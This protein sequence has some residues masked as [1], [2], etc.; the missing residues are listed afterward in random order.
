MVWVFLA[1]Y[2]AG[3]TR[4]GPGRPGS[5]R[6]GSTR[7]SSAGPACAAWSPSRRRSSSPRAS[8]DREI[9]LLIAFTVVAGTLF[10]QGLT[11]PWLA[12]RLDVPP[13]DP[14]DDALARATLLQQASK[15]GFTEL[16][17]AGVRR[18]AR[19]HRPDPAADRPAQLRGLGAPRHDRRPGVAERP[20]RPGPARDD[21]GRAAPGAGD[22]QVGHG[23]LRGDRRRARDA[24]RRGVDDRRRDRGARA[25]QAGQ[26]DPLPDRRGVRRPAARSRWPTYLAAS[27]ARPASTTAPSGSR[28]ATAWSAATSPAATPHRCSTP[29]RTSTRSQHPVMQSVEPDEDWRWCYVHHLTA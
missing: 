14:M 29:P 11:L 13:P 22:P 12:R 10:I 18:P 7:S 4:S 5:C 3:A 25:D 17:E 19:R 2:A 20:L 26:R 24:R 27:S 16:A 21:R 8:T 15:A 6:R 1:R 23:R 28:C 9:L